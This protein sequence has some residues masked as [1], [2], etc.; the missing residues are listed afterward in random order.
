MGEKQEQSQYQRHT[1][2]SPR[3]LRRGG[4]PNFLRSARN[5]TIQL[6]CSTGSIL[7]IQQTKSAA[8]RFRQCGKLLKPNR[9]E[10]AERLNAAVC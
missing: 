4:G 7:Q 2:K 3:A 1:L 10:V 8:L 9:G 6:C 5:Q